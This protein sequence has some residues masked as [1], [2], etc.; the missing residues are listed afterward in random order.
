MTNTWTLGYD[1]TGTL[2][3]DAPAGQLAG[4]TTGTDGIAWTAEQFA[5]HP[6]TVRICQDAGATDT[7]ADV[8]D[9]ESGAATIADAGPWAKAAAESFDKGTRP[10][11][12]SPVIY[13]S[14]DNLTPV[15]NALVAAGMTSGNIGLWV[16]HW[17]EPEAV[18]IASVASASGPFP[19]HAYQFASDTD[20][21]IDIFSDAWL[22]T[23]SKAPV[24]T[25]PPPTPAPQTGTQDGWFFCVNCKGLFYQP[26]QSTS[27]CPLGGNHVADIK[28]YNY[29]LAW[30]VG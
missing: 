21:D 5:A 12:R 28:G 14:Q 2:E 24:T 3:H 18:A 23:V 4:Y 10:G 29:Q 13:A 8:L 20:Y 25:P 27:H 9:V 19:I 15:A 7:T 26:N 22:S 6:G 1:C 30:K 11:Q 16:A 17:G